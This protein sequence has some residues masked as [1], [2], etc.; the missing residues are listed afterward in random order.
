MTTLHN[1]ISIQAPIEKIWDA[2]AVIDKLEEFDPT[3]QKAVAL[4][5]AK[6]GLDAKRK[7]HMKDGKNWFEEKVTEFKP[8]EALCYQLTDCSFPITGLSHSYSFEKNGSGVKVK[9]LM[10][11]T[12][13]FGLLGRLLD[14]LMIRK[15]T[16]A[17]I[18]KFFEGLKEYVEKS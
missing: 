16:D 8:N 12:V 9:Q 4:S 6:S 10:K 14:R 7:V 15:Q 1:E 5:S 11:Y 17:G 2:L 13:K 18:K 3:V